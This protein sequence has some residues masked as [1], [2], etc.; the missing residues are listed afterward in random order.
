MNREER[1]EKIEKYGQGYDLLTSA[2]SGIPRQAW[3]FKPS[4]E[5]WCI[6]E[7]IVHLGDG[8]SIAALRCRKLIVE[9][10]SVLIGYEEA[11][12]AGALEYLKQDPADSLEIIR[13]AR[14]TTYNLLKTLPDE[15]FTH[16]VTHPEHSGEFTFE[17]WLDIYARH[18]PNHIDQIQHT[19]QAWKARKQ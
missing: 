1:N 19:Y 14:R 5:D 13:L 3:T 15:V 16:S 7:I 8:E 18:I 4:A 12:W 6:H 2:L 9:P 17:R 11:R 10:G